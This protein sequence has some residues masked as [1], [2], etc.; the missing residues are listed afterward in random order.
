MLGKRKKMNIKNEHYFMYYLFVNQ[1]TKKEKGKKKKVRSV[2]V[3]FSFWD[4]HNFY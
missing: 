4:N 1:T 2:C 3:C